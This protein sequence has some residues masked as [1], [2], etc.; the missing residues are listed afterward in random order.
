AVGRDMMESDAPGVE[1]QLRQDRPC[2]LLAG[3]A[4][5]ENAHFLILMQVPDDLR[6]NKRNGGELAGPVVA[7]VRPRDP[8]RLV[9]LPLGRHAETGRGG[10]RSSHAHFSVTGTSLIPFRS[11]SALDARRCPARKVNLDAPAG[12]ST[13]P[14]F[15]CLY[16]SQ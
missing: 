15:A 16:V 14:T 2:Q 7:L 9:R 10:H 3:D 1:R 5:D 8:C 6:V 4:V 13:S 12:S 11:M